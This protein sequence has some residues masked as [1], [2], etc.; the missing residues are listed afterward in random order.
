[1]NNQTECS[2][3]CDRC[4]RETIGDN[5]TVFDD[6]IL[7]DDCLDETTTV[8]SHCDERIWCEDNAGTE[9]MPLCETCYDNHYTTC[10]ECGRIIHQDYA[11]YLSNDDDYPYCDCCYNECRSVSIHDYSY[12]PDPIFYG[13]GKRFF[14][15]ELEI[16]D[17]GRD[18]NNADNILSA[19]NSGGEKI[20][21]KNDGSLDDG[22]EIIT[23]PMTLHYHK[24][25]MPW[26]EIMYQAVDMGYRSHKT[27]TCG[28]H[29]HVNRNAFGNTR[30]EQDEAIS[31]ILYFVEH[32]WNE[33][34]K[35]SRRTEH[36]MNR[37]A[38]RYGYKN[39]PKDILD[40]AK[41][42][43]N[44]RYTCVNI[45]NWNT[46]EFRMFRGTLKY[47]TLIATLELVDQIC[48]FAVIFTDEEL[49]KMSWTE[50]VTLLDE[51]TCSELITYLKERRLYV[52]PPITNE[53][54]E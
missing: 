15:V 8:C 43:G 50:F 24:N 10:E 45:T 21:I 2:H 4:G 22:M 29:V 41:K 28:L 23:H 30:E 27:S 12:K 47:N 6:E 54:D 37:W 49:R 5:Y 7:C 51:S 34:L 25:E 3:F 14:G 13:N 19:A 20:Y 9:E 18:S 38:A 26:R 53:E 40:H 52:N 48:E 39:N 11:H 33:L 46:V 1:M 44:G 36:Q 35:F 17:G 32:H 16:D 42:E 31:R